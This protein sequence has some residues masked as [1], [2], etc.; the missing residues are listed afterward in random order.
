MSIYLLPFATVFP[1]LIFWFEP[2]FDRLLY[3]FLCF[4]LKCFFSIEKGVTVYLVTVYF[5]VQNYH[6]LSYCIK[7]KIVKIFLQHSLCQW[8]SRICELLVLRTTWITYNFLQAQKLKLKFSGFSLLL[9]FL[10]TQWY[11][12]LMGVSTNISHKNRHLQRIFLS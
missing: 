8:T 4:Q 9:K 1:F 11:Y 3:K 6:G 7:T 12:F 10:N 2:V 5:T